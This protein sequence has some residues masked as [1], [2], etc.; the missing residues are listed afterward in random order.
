MRFLVVRASKSRDTG[1]LVGSYHCVRRQKWSNR[2]TT[3]HNLG[4]SRTA[5]GHTGK[6]KVDCG[7]LAG[8]GPFRASTL[9]ATWTKP[10]V[11]PARC[12]MAFG[13]AAS[14]TTPSQSRFTDRVT[15]GHCHACPDPDA[16][17]ACAAAARAA[18][19]SKPLSRRASVGP[20]AAHGGLG[21]P[22]LV[23]PAGP[24]AGRS[25]RSAPPSLLSSWS[26][27]ARFSGG[28]CR[29]TAAGLNS[30]PRP[31]LW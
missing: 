16:A 18:P 23:A 25:T 13:P 5:S 11:L 2:S 1:L 17:A 30:T 29:R 7:A 6:R 24:T 10:A 31:L 12:P 21:A 14:P 8:V 15:S 28:A 27:V 4:V 3:C 26:K 9:V 22:G 20:A 19:I